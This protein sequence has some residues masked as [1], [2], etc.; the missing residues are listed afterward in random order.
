MPTVL[1]TGADRNIGLEF[2]R[3]YRSDNWRVIAIVRYE[4]SLQQI[5]AVGAEGYHL[6]LTN[7]KGIEELSRKLSDQPID[8]LISNAGVYEGVNALI[9]DISPEFI[10]MS[11][12]VNAVAPI[13]LAKCF[14]PH[15]KAGQQRKMIAITS[16]LGSTS[17][18][19]LPG[20]IAYR[21]SKAALNAAW[22]AFSIE[23][24]DLIAVAMR[25][26]RV[27]TH[28]T[29]HKGDLSVEESVSSMRATIGKLAPS[30][31]GKYMNHNA[32]ETPW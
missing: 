1:V 2:V 9:D 11:F 21:S 23:E 32:E 16:V 19:N 29:G 24:P 26:G 4:E 13:V 5:R 15:L 12:A 8:V 25:P 3:Q 14:R 22:K 27:R 7:L 31:S 6:D 20:H 28:M 30:D 17:L 10:A 18:N